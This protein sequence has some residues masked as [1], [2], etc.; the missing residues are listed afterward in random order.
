MSTLPLIS[1]RLFVAAVRTEGK[2][3]EK[4]DRNEAAIRNSA[5]K[6]VA[7]PLEI[8]ES[9]KPMSARVPRHLQTPIRA[10]I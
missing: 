5:A 7:I 8:L 1:H 2:S 9:G 6:A 3:P 10:T 4:P